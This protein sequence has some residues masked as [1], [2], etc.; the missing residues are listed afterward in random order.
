MGFSIVSILLILTTTIIIGYIL[1]LSLPTVGLFE[2]IITK[3]IYIILLP[4][5][6][7]IKK[8]IANNVIDKSKNYKQILMDS[9]KALAVESVKYVPKEIVKSVVDSLPNE[10]IDDERC[11]KKPEIKTFSD[12]DKISISEN[13]PWDEKVDN[14]V[15]NKGT[16][17][18]IY[19]DERVVDNT[20]R[21][22]LY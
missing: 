19:W 3:I 20:P 9:Q 16:L 22:I 18:D 4:V 15:Y 17:D 5:P 14:C 2:T 1:L 8:N 13:L 6:E 12:S 11:I 10:L 7:N 21:V